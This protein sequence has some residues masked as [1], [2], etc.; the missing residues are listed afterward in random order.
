MKLD[1]KL[2]IIYSNEPPGARIALRMNYSYSRSRNWLKYVYFKIKI[3][4]IPVK[5]ATTQYWKIK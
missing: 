3:W 1:K 4:G 5:S 2:Y